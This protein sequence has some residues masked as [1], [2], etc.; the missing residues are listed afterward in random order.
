MKHPI[1]EQPTQPLAVRAAPSLI[2]ELN[3]AV[4]QTGAS[5]SRLVRS[6]IE[7]GLKACRRADKKIPRLQPREIRKI[8][9]PIMTSLQFPKK[10]DFSSPE[11][12]RKKLEEKANDLIWKIVRLQ[13]LSLIHI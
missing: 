11:W 4:Q 2:R 5:R 6:F 12:Q 10:P 8:L 9:V 13:D 7:Q 3:H 1:R